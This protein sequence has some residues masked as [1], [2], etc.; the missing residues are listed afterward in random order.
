MKKKTEKNELFGIIGLG[1]FGSALMET[2]TEAGKEVIAIDRDQEKINRAAALTE[3]AFAVDNLSRETLER[4][5]I[6]NCDVVV[7]CIGEDVSTS[8]LT[9]LTV[10]RMGVPRVIAKVKSEDHGSVLKVL[11]AEVVYPERDMGLRLAN[12]LISPRFFEY[13]SLSNEI[14]IMEIQ[15]TEKVEGV[16]VAQLDIR[17][18]FGLNIIAVKYKDNVITEIGPQ[19]LLHSGSLVTVIG[20]RENVYRFENYLQ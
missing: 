3:N 19:T 14:D 20:R 10:I 7:V 13:L 8:I 5:S 11:G 4:V 17:K 18:K 16:S 6:Q 1:R 2:L 15:L 9:T 12:R